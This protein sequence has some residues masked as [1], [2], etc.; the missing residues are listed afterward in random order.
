MSHSFQLQDPWAHLNKKTKQIGGAGEAGKAD[1][2]SYTGLLSNVST[3]KRDQG[4]ENPGSG[5]S[6]CRAEKSKAAEPVVPPAC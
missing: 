2:K 6:L 4:K 3:T 5:K 1:S